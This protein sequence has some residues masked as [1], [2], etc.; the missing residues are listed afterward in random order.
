[1]MTIKKDYLY[2]ITLKDDLSNIDEIVKIC[3]VSKD[4]FTGEVIFRYTKDSSKIGWYH[5][6]KRL[7][8]KFNVQELGF[9]KDF[10]EYTL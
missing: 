6:I 2:R 8:D 1:M 3:S 10:P 5:S 7:F 9:Y 4:L